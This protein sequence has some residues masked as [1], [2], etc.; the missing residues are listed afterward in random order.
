MAGPLDEPQQEVDPNT[1]RIIVIPA[2]TPP[3]N[4]EVP[5]TQSDGWYDAGLDAPD[6]TLEQTQSVQYDNYDPYVFNGQS[7]I[8]EAS[9]GDGDP[10]FLDG[11][12]T[13]P[14]SPP[15]G[16]VAL[17]A[18]DD[19]GAKNSV[20]ALSSSGAGTTY[21][22][23]SSTIV[24]PTPN[25]LDQY[26]TYTYTASVYLLSPKQYEQL[27]TTKQKNVSGY[28]LL[29]QTG[30]ADAT[31]KEV[32]NPWFTDD[33]YIDHIT[34]ENLFP[35]KAT[36]AAHMVTSLKFTVVEPANITL[37]DRLYAAV[38][39]HVAK[40]GSGAIN[41]ASVT[42]LMVIRFY[43]YDQAGNLVKATANAEVSGRSGAVIEKFIPFTINSVSW[44]VSNKLVSY[45]F[46]CTPTSQIVS[47]TT[48]RGTVPYDIEFSA[49]S[50]KDF[51]SGSQKF[52]STNADPE[53]PGSATTATTGATPTYADYDIPVA[54]GPVA[55]TY[56]DYDIPVAP[57]PSKAST[58]PT[59]KQSSTS[60]LMQ[61]LNEYQKEMVKQGK[62]KF[63]DE[64][65]IEFLDPEIASA[66]LVL[67]GT[68]KNKAATPMAQPSS[69]NPKTL[70]NQ[71]Q[72]D[73]SIRNI[74]ITAGQQ[75]VQIIE[76]AIRNSSYILNQANSIKNEEKGVE[77]PSTSAN[78]AKPLDWFLIT[79]EAVQKA[80]QYDTERNDYAY[81]ITYRVS[82]Y[83]IPNFDSRYFGL[84]KFPGVHKSYKYWFTG[85][86]IAVLDYQANFNAL[87]T[88]TITGDNPKNPGQYDI[89][90]KITSSMRDLIRYNVFASSS[91]SKIGAKNQGNEIGAN[92]SEYLYDIANLGECR[93]RIIGD[94]AWI[95]QGS[96]FAGLPTGGA[97]LPDGSINFDASQVF[98]EIAWQRPEDYSLSTGIADPYG[99]TQQKTGDRAPIQSFVYLTTQVINEFK[100][101]RFEQTL[102]GSIYPFEIPAGTN[103]APTAPK[104][105]AADAGAGAGRSTA[106]YAAIDPRRLDLRSGQ[107]ATPAVQNPLSKVKGVIPT[108]GASETPI[109][110]DAGTYTDYDMPTVAPAPPAEPITS[111]GEAT[112]ADFYYEPPA[113]LGEDNNPTDTPPQEMYWEP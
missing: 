54:A 87:Y 42:Y 113:K 6:R 110:T 47:L 62:Y 103:A 27:V 10:Y 51:L 46:D 77:E 80:D 84:S 59:K 45:D 92:A 83:K 33:F 85:D 104:K 73:H 3:T 12:S 65:Y 23:T 32:R 79:T 41:Y 20:N 36:R 88:Q 90:K 91:E 105:G 8:P 78:Q 112:V 66:T 74:P 2:T 4:A 30:G 53:N 71:P 57:A 98:F 49:T 11:K 75:V 34:L 50:V 107:S 31:S 86:N 26:E 40:G 25:P 5:L 14:P 44:G 19:K 93:L 24:N 22:T 100:G 35:G 17:S 37:L 96:V 72:T 52:G 94:P 16:D 68:D 64:Y 99:R 67:P 48:N 109:S 13:I 82:R 18:P 9:Y 95:Q 56:A 76:L 38:Q 61:A 101:G 58:A 28:Q 15:L 21:S 70:V 69:Q 106:E 1:G 97:F 55:A 43:G 102:I 111:N 81:K 108:P 89:R 60:G 7:T 39:D 29:F 63:P